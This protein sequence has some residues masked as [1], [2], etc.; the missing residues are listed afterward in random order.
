MLYIGGKLFSK[1]K[2]IELLAHCVYFK[3]HIENN[4]TTTE[5]KFI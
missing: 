4:A 5:D 3:G 2:H 1:V